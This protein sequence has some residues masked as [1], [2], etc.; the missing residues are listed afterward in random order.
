MGRQYDETEAEYAERVSA[1]EREFGRKYRMVKIGYIGA[2][3]L[4]ALAMLCFIL[5]IAAG[6]GATAGVGA[7]LLVSA[8]VT[9]AVSGIYHNL[10][11]VWDEQNR[12]R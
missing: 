9:V 1:E 4:F 7:M 6:S 3:T 5:G 11:G 8:I 12:R 2:G 10:S